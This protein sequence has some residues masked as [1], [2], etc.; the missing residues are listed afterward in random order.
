MKKILL[1][2]IILFIGEMLLAQNIDT[3][4][5]V[6]WINENSIDLKERSG[7]TQLADKL[8]DKTIIGLGECVHGSK[9]I[10]KTRIDIAKALIENNDFNNVAFEMPFNIGLRINHFYKQVKEILKK[11]SRM[12]IFSQIPQI[13]WILSNG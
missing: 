7:F 11:S 8:N 4:Q 5:F 1:S 9:T 2:T 10:S 3:I 6:R 13:F 12:V